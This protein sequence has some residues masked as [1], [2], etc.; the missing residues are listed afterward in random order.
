M[1]LTGGFLPV[2]ACVAAGSDGTVYNVNADAMAVACAV[3]FRAER[4]LFLTDVNGVR[5]AE[6]VVLSELSLDR[7]EQLISGGVATG[8]MQAKLRSAAAALQGGVPEVMISP[9]QAPE[10]LTRLMRGEAIGT[11]VRKEVTA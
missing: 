8:G 1:L 9:G 2:V 11:R 5:G 4:L 6:G 3:G 7:S 10:V